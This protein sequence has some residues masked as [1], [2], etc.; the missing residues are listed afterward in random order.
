MKFSVYC[1]DYYIVSDIQKS[2]V[3]C[4][5]DDMRHITIFFLLA[6]ACL[7][8]SCC[9]SARWQIQTIPYSVG[10]NYANIY[11]EPVLLDTKTGRTWSLSVNA[12]T[13]YM[14]RPFIV[15]NAPGKTVP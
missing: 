11:Q 7:L 10:T 1:P 4:L 2:I 3:R 15:T 14:W 13:G 9:S 6:N 12:E 5:Y 8:T